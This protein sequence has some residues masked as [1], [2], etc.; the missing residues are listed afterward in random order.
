MQLISADVVTNEK[1]LYLKGKE[2]YNKSIATLN[3]FCSNYVNAT[4]ATNARC[5]GTN[6]IHPEGTTDLFEGVDDYQKQHDMIRDDREEVSDYN[7]MKEATH[8]NTDGLHCINEEYWMAS[9][10]AFAYDDEGNLCHNASY[11]TTFSVVYSQKNGA[12]TLKELL[13]INKIG[14]FSNRESYAGVRVV[15]NL[16]EEVKTNNGTGEKERPY[17]L[18]L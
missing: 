8:Q 12:L 11:S 4:Y 10:R 9:R 5:V 3:N 16:R 15:V 6:P 7:A 2:G 18:V 14:S 1:G 17:E 13:Y